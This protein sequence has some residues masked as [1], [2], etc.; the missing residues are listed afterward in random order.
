MTRRSRVIIVASIMIGFA[1]LFCPKSTDVAVDVDSNTDK[2]ETTEA[3]TTLSS[4]NTEFF[5]AATSTT[6]TSST[7]KT[8]VTTYTTIV[9]NSYLTSSST[10]V[11]ST[12]PNAYA[13]A[14][15]TEQDIINLAKIL[16]VECGGV[17][18]IT[19]QAC[20]AWTVCNHVDYG[21]ATTISGAI[22]YKGHFAWRSNAPVK[23]NLYELAADVLERWSRERNGETDVGRVLPKGYTYFYGDGVHNYFHN[24]NRV[25]WDYSLQTPY[26]S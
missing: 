19:E 24:G 11:V 15:Y 17:K 22:K 10:F 20:V 6:T 4:L 2:T 18:S 5:E 8:K 14:H 25:L 13:S 26:D 7:S 3:T 12:E 1:A 9:T 21:Y 16:W 23:D